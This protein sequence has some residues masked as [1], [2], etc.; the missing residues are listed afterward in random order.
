MM[1]RRDGVQ[2]KMLCVTL[3]S[4]M[5][6]E[7]F[8]R[9]LDGL[10]D[11]SFIYQRVESL[12]S[13]RGRPSI[14]PVVVVKMLLLGYLYGID[15]E[16]RL[17]QEVRVNIAYRWFLGIDL[18]EPVPDHSTFSQ[19]RRRKFNGAALFEELFDE[20]VRKCI[21]YGLIDGKLLLTDSTHV[22]ANARNDVL[23]R[24]AV[25]AEPSAYLQRLNEQA[26]KDGV[27]P[28]HRKEKKK[29]CKELV[30]SLADPDAGFMKR[31]GKPLGFYYLSHQTCDARHGLITD[32]HTTPGNVPDSTVH[33]E[34]IKRQIAVFGFKPEAVCADSAYDSSEIHKDM[35]DMGIRTYIPKRNLPKPASGVFSEADFI[36]DRESDTLTCP[37]ACRLIFSNYRDRLGQKRYKASAGECSACPL[38]SRCISGEAKYRV[39]ERAYFKWASEEQH[40]RN[41]GTPGYYEALRLRKIYCEG[42]FSH[43]KAEHNLRRLRKRGLGK[44]HEHCLL[45]ATALNLK[46]MVKLLTTR[47]HPGVSL[48][49][50]LSAIGRS[51]ML[52]PMALLS[53]GPKRGSL[54]VYRQRGKAPC[55]HPVRVR[56]FLG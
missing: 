7:H 5:P 37:N 46:R 31:T 20:V 17:E 56:R 28:K 10:M 40:L 3:E 25:E 29:A 8:L 12:Y 53:T 22:R 6:Q 21:E 41:D 27:Y 45:S 11:F 13:R 52:Y 43:Q 9:R 19:L 4:L 47:K 51:S 39:V 15:S 34:R 1:T 50:T 26:V 32:V 48:R 18:D 14:D 30:K 44:A 49:K 55:F 36:Y 42:N 23:E 24:V 38:R 54:L 35:L 16:R 2:Q 33:S